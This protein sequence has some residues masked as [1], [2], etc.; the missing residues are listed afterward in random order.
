MFDAGQGREPFFECAIQVLRARLVKRREARVDFQKVIRTRLQTR[1][2]G[3]RLARAANEE[4]GSRQQ[5]ERK[6][7]LHHDERIAG[8]K[9]PIA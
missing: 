7:N 1:I 6:C 3:G 2:N 8:Q 5:R 9:L 4:R